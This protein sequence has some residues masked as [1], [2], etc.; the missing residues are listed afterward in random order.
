MSK[1]TTEVRFICEQA[2]GLDESVGFDSLDEVLTRETVAKV[3]NGIDYPIFDENYRYVLNK[4]ILEHYYT[5]EIGLET[6]GLWKLKMRTKLNEVMPYYNKL[7][8]SELIE[9]NPLA[10]TMIKTERKV[11]N[12]GS[13]IRQDRNESNTK[14]KSKNKANTLS[15]NTGERNSNRTEWDLYSDT[16]QGGLGHFTIDDDDEIYLTNA[17]KKTGSESDKSKDSNVGSSKGETDYEDEVSSKGSGSNLVNNTEKYLETVSG[18]RGGVGLAKRLV[19]YRE[20]FLNIDR[21]IID[22]LKLLFFGLWE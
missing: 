12:E 19:E 6:V 14:S 5:R 15:T 1:F 13:S 8:L 11:D 9:F 18:N 22:E 17:R 3:F 10:D 2:A 4:K 16:P 20:S 7:Y 21:M